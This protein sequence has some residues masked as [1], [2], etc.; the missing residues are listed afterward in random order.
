MRWSRDDS[1]LSQAR[2]GWPHSP[3]ATGSR[4]Q[5]RMISAV[6]NS[7]PTPTDRHARQHRRRHVSPPFCRATAKPIYY[8]KR[9]GNTTSSMLS[10]RPPS[11][12]TPARPW[13]APARPPSH[14]IGIEGAEVNLPV[15]APPTGPAGRA[16]APRLLERPPIARGSALPQVVQSALIAPA[17]E[18]VAF[19]A[20]ANADFR[21]VGS[22]WGVAG[23]RVGDWRE[24]FGG[25]RF[26]G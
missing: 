12:T 13:P 3:L 10:N 6:H 23:L 1:R 4:P 2:D 8:P 11:N 18:T 24:T 21:V 7:L 5:H 20:V 14:S 22:G 25:Q 15:G 19:T 16:P 17:T 26:R 9:L